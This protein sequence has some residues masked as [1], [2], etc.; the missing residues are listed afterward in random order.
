MRPRATPRAGSRWS[1]PSR[2]PP[3]P[4]AL[5]SGSGKPGGMVGIADGVW[6][7]WR[8]AGSGALRLLLLA[9]PL[10]PTKL[11]P[12][13][14]TDGVDAW[15][16]GVIASQAPAPPAL[17]RLAQRAG[18]RRCGDRGDRLRRAAARAP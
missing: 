10:P 14:L 1:S 2:W 5:S 13:A 7:A 6:A 3:P 8:D 9:E 4:C 15:G 18:R 11:V 16:R 17:R 12:D